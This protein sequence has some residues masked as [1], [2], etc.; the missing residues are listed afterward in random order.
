MENANGQVNKLGTY[1]TG[2]TVRK[3]CWFYGYMFG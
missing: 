3:H 2:E 1:Y